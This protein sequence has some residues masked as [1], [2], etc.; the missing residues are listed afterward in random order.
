[1]PTVK[2]NNE[3]LY[4]ELEGNGPPLVLVHSL[5]TCTALWRDAIAHWKRTRTVLAMDARGHG[6]S[7]NNGGVTLENIANDLGALV[8]HLKL[9]TVDVVGISMGGLISTHFYTQ[10][11]H[12]VRRIVLADTFARMPEGDKKTAFLRDKLA[13]MN[14]VDFGNEYASQTLLPAS[15][16]EWHQPLAGWVANT[17]SA[18]Y[19]QTVE[20]LFAQDARAL[21]AAIQVP[22]LV[23]IGDQDL[24]TPLPLSQEV[25]GLVPGAKFD[26]IPGAAH[27]ANLDNP[28]G[29]HQAVDQFLQSN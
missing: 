7:S 6:K 18:A 22:A 17:S 23:V 27:L 15:A 8:D 24:R 9:G 10:A 3:D 19:M 5:G 14:M 13:A 2:L 21:M 11:P 12:R 16:A 1:M 4:Y 26:I 29:F 28:A 25:A 20:S